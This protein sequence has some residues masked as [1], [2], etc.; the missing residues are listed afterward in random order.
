MSAA[1]IG[2]PGLA[3]ERRRDPAL[4]ELDAFGD[5]GP[6]E[7]APDL[8]SDAPSLARADLATHD[9]GH[10][11]VV[12][13]IDERE[14]GRLDDGLVELRVGRDL[15]TDAVHEL[16]DPVEIALADATHGDLGGREDARPVR[17]DPQL[18]VR[19]RVDGPARVPDDRAAQPDLLDG[20]FDRSDRD[21]VA[22]EEL[23]LD[24]D[25]D[26]RQVVEDDGLAGDRERRE[27]ET[28]ARDDAPEPEEADDEQQD[29][30]DDRDAKDRAH[31]RLEGRRP[32]AKLLRVSRPFLDE[33]RLRSHEAARRPRRRSGS[34]R[35][36]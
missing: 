17:D 13:V 33:L 3:A 23:A 28:E 25:E 4:V 1:I 12:G 35:R 10:P 32:L 36:R 22:I 8:S 18:P 31:E 30:R 14:R 26:A 29:D 9:R 21:R 5:E 34:G 6:I 2:G 11:E 15:L 24:D 16:D 7:A 20:A 27:E 19:D